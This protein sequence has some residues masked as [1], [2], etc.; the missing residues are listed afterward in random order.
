[1]GYQALV[2]PEVK[3]TRNF[4]ESKLSLL[5]ADKLILRFIE[6]HHDIASSS[7]RLLP[8]FDKL[9]SELLDSYTEPMNKRHLG[10]IDVGIWID[11]K[12]ATET[13]PPDRFPAGFL[14]WCAFSRKKWHGIV[15]NRTESY[16]CRPQTG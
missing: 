3:S 8:A 11:S 4:F 9:R 13:Y 2:L 15:K 16:I 12:T 1:M 7:R 5:P 14:R 6:K 10:Y